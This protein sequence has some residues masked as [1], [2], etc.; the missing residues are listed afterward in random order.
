[1]LGLYFIVVTKVE[2]QLI[3]N[4]NRP[5]KRSYMAPMLV[6]IIRQCNLHLKI[7]FKS[8]NVEFLIFRFYTYNGIIIQIDGNCL[9]NSTV[10]STRRVAINLKVSVYHPNLLVSYFSCITV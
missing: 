4:S 1:M 7:S 8:A 9:V 3:P 2:Q 5:G 6:Y 10:E